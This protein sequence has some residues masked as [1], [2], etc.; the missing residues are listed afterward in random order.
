MQWRAEAFTCTSALAAIDRSAS[1]PRVTQPAAQST[2]PLL[3]CL[4]VWPLVI[5]L[6]AAGKRG[7]VPGLYTISPV[8]SKFLE[9]NHAAAQR[10]TSNGR[11]LFDLE[12]L[13]CCDF[14]RT[15]VRGLQS[16]FYLPHRLRV[17]HKGF[18]LVKCTNNRAHPKR[19]QGETVPVN[20]DKQLRQSP[21][22][23]ANDA[24]SS[25]PHYKQICVLN[26]DGKSHSLIRS[27]LRFEAHA[28][29]IPAPGFVVVISRQQQ[30]GKKKKNI[31]QLNR[32]SFQ[33]FFSSV[34]FFFFFFYYVF[35]TLA[36]NMFDGVFD[37]SQWG[38]KEL[39]CGSLLLKCNEMAND[40]FYPI[41]DRDYEAFWVMRCC[42][43]E[44][45]CFTNRQ[46][47]KL[48]LF[49]SLKCLTCRFKRGSAAQ[50]G[51]ESRICCLQL[52]AL[53]NLTMPF[54]ALSCRIVVLPRVAS[55]VR[56]KHCESQIVHFKMLE[57]L[58]RGK[59]L[60]HFKL[61]ILH[62][63]HLSI[64]NLVFQSLLGKIQMNPVWKGG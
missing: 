14:C 31:Q 44:V 62:K 17:D 58:H 60:P 46:T 61:F 8:H 50:V 47:R 10:Q 38:N 9:D 13:N 63:A 18:E 19:C 40:G 16:R 5:C 15:T 27:Q 54:V 20:A 57:N 3:L 45:S 2:S 51:S 49:F 7:K 36:W 26:M 56:S 34:F 1:Q 35:K 42:V 23:A 6:G 32:F 53:K 39:E 52:R 30:L 33:H 43:Y 12:D 24:T 11:V 59:T 4:S 21:G 55:A 29:L 41:S 28:V 25:L 37:G 48:L 22:R 64:T